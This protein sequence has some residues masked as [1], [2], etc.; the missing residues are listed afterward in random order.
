MPSH[1]GIKIALAGGVVMVALAAGV[2]GGAGLRNATTAVPVAPPAP[3]MA[4]TP[5][6][7]PSDVPAP[8]TTNK[9]PA[10]RNHFLVPSEIRD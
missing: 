2:G 4:P 8:P 7:A 1:A 5:E 6:P 10:V 3:L 9:A